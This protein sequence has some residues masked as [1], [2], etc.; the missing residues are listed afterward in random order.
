MTPAPEN[1]CQWVN[2]HG[3]LH[4]FATY[5]GPTQTQ[6][7]IKPLHHYVACRLVLEGGFLPEEITP[8]PPFRARK[9]DGWQLTY[10]PT[11]ATGSERTLLGG[12]RTKSVDVVI[13]KNGLGPAMA[14]S[15][16]GAIGAF[17]NLTNRMEEAVGDCTNLHITYPAM[18]TGFLF[19]MRAHRQDAV[20]AATATQPGAPAPGRAIGQNDIAIQS[21][22][23]P[24]EAIVRF[25]NALRELPAGVAYAT[26]LAAT[27]QSLLYWLTR[28]G[29]T[30]GR[31]LRAIQMRTVLYASKIFL[32]RS[33]C[34]MTS[35]TFTA[36]PI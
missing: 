18:V 33:I 26:T 12:L 6:Q 31:C 13:V 17:R 34:G 21:S 5:T 14:I 8:R 10:D 32:K 23:E 11:A 30:P 27:R 1:V 20:V 25:H 29:S 35:D 3:A 16:K 36:P 4:A 7:H 22:G 19:I 24:V 2:L 28:P 15:C 9:R